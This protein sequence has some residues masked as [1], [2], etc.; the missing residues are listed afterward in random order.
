MCIMQLTITKEAISMLKK[1]ALPVLC[2]MLSLICTVSYADI[3]VWH[4][5]SL[6]IS[7]LKKVF[8]FPPDAQLNAGNQLMPAKQLNANLQDW[9][10][11]GAK[12]GLGKKSKLTIKTLDALL[13]DMKFIYGDNISAADWENFSKRAAE[14]G[15][16][17]FVR[18]NLTQ[19]FETEHVPEKINTYTVYREIERRDSKG[20]L[21]ETLRIPEEKTE[22]IPAHDV[23]YLH[24]VCEP[25]MY[26]TE[27]PE[28]DHVG[29]VNYSIYREYQGG[30]VIKVVENIVKASMK[31]LFTQK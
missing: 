10:V 11:E 13:K 7:D 25:K 9:A 8:I 28:D 23:T 30:P 1:F 2:I 20:K 12:S 24:T 26:L 27:D 29:A 3:D 16:R 4:D 17:A 22:V 18:I 6:K 14:M 15:Y 5:P 21:I 31:N 19:N